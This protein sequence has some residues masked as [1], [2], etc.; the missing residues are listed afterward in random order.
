MERNQNIG[1]Q[2][3]EHISWDLLHHTDRTSN[4]ATGAPQVKYRMILETLSIVGKLYRYLISVWYIYFGNR[5]LPKG[6]NKLAVNIKQFSKYLLLM[7][8][9]QSVWHM[10]GLWWAGVQGNL[11]DMSKNQ[12]RWQ[13]NTNPW[14]GL[15]VHVTKFNLNA[16]E[17]KL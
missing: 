1:K 11:N 9:R 4:F 7:R 15:Q 14:S 12:V 17:L 8:N 6:N 2:N 16:S 10:S 3:R 13:Y 5:W